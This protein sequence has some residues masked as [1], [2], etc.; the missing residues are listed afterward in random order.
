MYNIKLLVYR[1]YVF[2]KLYRGHGYPSH[3]MFA[4]IGNNRYTKKACF[5]AIRDL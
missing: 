3:E 4:N 5:T 2:V 1:F